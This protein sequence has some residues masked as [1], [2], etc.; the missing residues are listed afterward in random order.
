MTIAIQSVTRNSALNV[1]TLHLDLYRW[2]IHGPP[3]G[4]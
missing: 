3:N 1:L 2:K 4:M